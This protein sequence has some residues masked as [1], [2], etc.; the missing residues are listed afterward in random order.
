MKRQKV[1]DKSSPGINVKLN[2]QRSKTSKK[3]KLHSNFSKQI[4]NMSDNFVNFSDT[5]P[6]PLTRSDFNRV[7][8]QING[9][10]NTSQ[11]VAYIDDFQYIVTNNII[12]DNL[13]W[14][15][16]FDGNGSIDYLNWFQ[17]TQFPMGYSWFGNEQQHY[18][19]RIDNSNVSNGTLKIVAKREAY[20]NQGITKQFRIIKN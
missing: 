20:T 13:V 11:V 17:Q 19:N 12:Y 16:E 18:T 7:L 2:I 9:E 14:S 8:I 10:N 15:D 4:S 3:R 5:S 6:N 1:A